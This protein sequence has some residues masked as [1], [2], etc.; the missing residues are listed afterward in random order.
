MA[1]YFFEIEEVEDGKIVAINPF[2]KE[3]NGSSKSEDGEDQSNIFPIFYIELSCDDSISENSSTKKYKISRL[4]R[5]VYKIF[6]N[7]DE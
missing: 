7:N 4:N 5:G 1:K 3:K 6:N 2:S